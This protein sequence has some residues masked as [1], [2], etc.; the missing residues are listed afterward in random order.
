M[1][2]QPAIHRAGLLVTLV[3][4]LGATADAGELRLQNGIRLEGRI[5]PMQSL[6]AH[7]NR[8]S[9][10]LTTYPILLVDSPLRQ[11]FVPSR[12]VVELNNDLDLSR[13]QTF[14]IRQTGVG[15]GAA[16]R[17]LGR[18]SEITP[19]DA[20]GR[21]RLTFLLNDRPTHI[22]QGI[23]RLTPRWTVVAGLN[24]NWKHA[25]TTSALPRKTLDALL[26]SVT[27]QEDSDDRLAIARFYLQAGLYKES[28][29][30]LETVHRE[31]PP[32]R[33]RVDELR[34]QLNELVG[35][36]I[37]NELR[38]RRTAGQHK[39]VRQALAAIPVNEMSAVVRRQVRQLEEADRASLEKRVR[40]LEQLKLL[41][42]KL[43]TDAERDAFRPIH[44]EIAANLDLESLPRLE[45][46]LGLL[47]D[48]TLKPRQKLALA[49]SGWMIGSALAFTQWQAAIGLA[50]AR[51][52]VQ[53]Y[54]RT[55]HESERLELLARLETFEGVGPERITQLIPLLPP[56]RPAAGLEP[57]V[58]IRIALE[59][60]RRQVAYQVLLP[61]EYNP[62]H[63]YPLLIALPAAGVA[64]EK[65]LAWWGGSA[66]RPL[67]AQHR[68]YI[69]LVPELPRRNVATAGETRR[70][71]SLKSQV[72]KPSHLPAAVHVAVIDALR[73]A[74]HRFH[75]DSDRVFLAGHA[76]GGSAAFEL[77]MSH[78]DLFAG[79]IPIAGVL[80]DCCKI[81]WSNAKNVP[82][83]IV[84]GELDSDKFVK[85]A[86]GLNRMLRY[87]FD[88]VFCQYIGRGNE[89]FYE[90]IYR[91]FDWMEGYR[92]TRFPKD[93]EMR[94][95]RQFDNRFFWIRAD[96]L[97][98]GTVIGE[99][100]RPVQLTARASP[101][102]TVTISGTGRQTTVWLA[103]GLVDYDRRVT[104][105]ISGRQ[106][107]NDFIEPDLR[108]I[109]EDFR[110]RGDRQ[111]VYWNRLVFK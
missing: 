19:F 43:D 85:N 17:S 33:K 27:D 77:G 21:R 22:V 12:R 93:I 98:L 70:Y 39:F 5:R 79:V 81:Y 32:I 42:A 31:F 44:A 107:F 83:Y 36:K 50:Q 47:D 48:A 10:R 55:P 18:P 9:G 91:L 100:K 66:R 97:K 92:R 111:K 78:P 40:A 35:Q 90:E 20:R 71:V 11:Y 99:R 23:T 28:R 24:F 61:P 30:E 72:A 41:I 38:R 6:S 105:R 86:R 4:V 87:R 52:V 56:S 26:R 8:N 51:Q 103:P 94:T 101:G 96:D 104:I 54:L 58:P 65:A 108:T 64:P 49:A 67:P 1:S 69:V 76:T 2:R 63:A 25:I 110:L 95:L 15:R 89:S 80:N 88:M 16:I 37:L 74:R 53:A 7:V 102:N 106:R 60:D 14:E 29:S 84:T 45:S 46:F 34:L 59:T 109:L 75:V 82:W 13:F 3:A 57:G 62:H 73:D 68:G